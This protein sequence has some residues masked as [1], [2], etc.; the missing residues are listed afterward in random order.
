[1]SYQ[2]YDTEG[3]ILGSRELGEADMFLSVYTKDFGSVRL[4]AKGI[5]FEKSKLRGQVQ[6]FTR[7]QVQFV[8]GRELW[9][10]TDARLAHVFQMLEKDLFRFQAA[11][12]IARFCK[13]IVSGSER[14]PALWQL[15][16]EVFAA[17]DS[18][19]IP[20]SGIPR[21][22][23]MFQI[24]A[25]QVLGYLPETCPEIVRSLGLEPF[26][27]SRPPLTL[28]ER[29]E[30]DTFLSSVFTYAASPDTHASLVP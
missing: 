9:R 10:L 30:L 5:R 14:D 20:A 21:L 27:N 18:A 16:E 17:L 26:E 22:L 2:A 19:G 28:S 15:L 25:F 8:I 29:R 13:E 6:L 11:S 1:M 12:A 3:F 4:L 23:Y 7:A 24:K